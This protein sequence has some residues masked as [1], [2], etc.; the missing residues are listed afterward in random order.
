MITVF[1]VAVA[2]R[3]IGQWLRSY[4]QDQFPLGEVV[5]VDAD[6]YKGF[7]I[8]DSYCDLSPANVAVRLENGNVWHYPVETVARAKASEFPRWISREIRRRK[9]N[10]RKL[11]A[12]P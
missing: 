5:R 1:Q 9:R 7:G 3:A 11:E 2:Y 6:S 10:A 8:I 12:Q 4:A